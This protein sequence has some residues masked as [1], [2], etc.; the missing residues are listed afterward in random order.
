MLMF[1]KIALKALYQLHERN[2]IKILLLDFLKR[3][4]NTYK[5]I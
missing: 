2:T 5:R 3:D 1:S 4:K